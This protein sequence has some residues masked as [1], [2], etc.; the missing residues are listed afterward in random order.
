MQ[1]GTIIEP[2]GNSYSAHGLEGQDTACGRVVV[3]DVGASMVWLVTKQEWA[4]WED[5]D[6]NKRDEYGCTFFD[7]W[8]QNGETLKFSNRLQGLVF[9][10]F[11]DED[12]EDDDQDDAD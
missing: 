7:S 12:D 8:S 6:P 9:E 11:D 5:H 3:E 1:N 4:E 10:D 2:I